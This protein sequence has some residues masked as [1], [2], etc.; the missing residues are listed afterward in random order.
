MRYIEG[1]LFVP[2]GCWG[3]WRRRYHDF[4][5]RPQVQ[6]EE[7]AHIYDVDGTWVPELCRLIV[8]YIG[9][10][11]GVDAKTIRPDDR[12]HVELNLLNGSC[13]NLALGELWTC[14]EMEVEDRR[15]IEH[16]PDWPKG[17]GETSVRDL[18]DYVN[19]IWTTA[20]SQRKCNDD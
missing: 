13:Q 7:W 6:L 19:G 18:I 10:C 11:F 15:R 3:S 14:I 16:W 8:D 2:F 20:N 4:K 1:F 9:S 5:Q 12:F 17:M